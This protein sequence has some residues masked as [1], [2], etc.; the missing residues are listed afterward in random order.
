MWHF[1]CESS[2]RT[3]CD[4][5]LWRC[6]I[7][8]V[9]LE[10]TIQRKKLKGIKNFDFLS[11]HK[12]KNKRKLWWEKGCHGVFIHNN[13]NR[14]HGVYNWNTFIL[15][16]TMLN[17]STIFHHMWHQTKKNRFWFFDVLDIV[18]NFL[19]ICNMMAWIL[20]WFSNFAINLTIRSLFS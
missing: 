20:L 8:L 17:G 19:V 13:M 16:L 3:I 15:K 12:N 10:N 2:Y 9:Q 18:G 6:I 4:S 14:F 1:C 5:F 11:N 7:A